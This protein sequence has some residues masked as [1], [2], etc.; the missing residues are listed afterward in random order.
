M[1]QQLATARRAEPRDDLVSVLLKS[2]VEGQLLSDPDFDAFF[3]LLLVAG[4]ETTTNLIGNTLLASMAHPEQLER[5]RR[6]P[7]LVP[8]L[9]EE[10]LRYC[11]PIQFLY[12]HATRDV[13]LAG[14]PIP[15][16]SL[17]LP[18][19]ASAN[20]DE[21]QFEDAG[22]F[23]VTR[24]AQGHLGFG[25]G[26]H[27]CL[28]ASLARLEARVALEELLARYARFE[29]AEGRVEYIDSFLVRGP[30][31]LPLRVEAA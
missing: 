23:D 1:R 16:G 12:R 24:N 5:V 31:R 15:A 7:R 3:L 14:V 27:F 11:G 25:L 8:S 17:V 30:K 13:E 6:D 19:L 18:L 21:R 29:P 4:N 2:E 26:I 22:R 9:V 10:G 28:G 20:R